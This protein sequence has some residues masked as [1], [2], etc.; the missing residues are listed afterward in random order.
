MHPVLARF[1]DRE[2]VIPTVV[3]DASSVYR[4]RSCKVKRMLL[5]AYKQTDRSTTVSRRDDEVWAQV[6]S[7][8]VDLEGI[9]PVYLQVA[10]N[11]RWHV[12]QWQLPAGTPL[13]AEN[14]LAGLYGVSRD[15]VRRAYGILRMYGMIATRR[16]AG[17]YLK[18][19]PDL[20]SVKVAPGS[21]ITAVMRAARSPEAMAALTPEGRALF[22]PVITVEEPGRLPAHYDSATTVVFVVAEKA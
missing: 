14:D 1:Q 19:R 20:Q 16:G 21:R 17:H 6:D 9:V 10:S 22:S 11:I 13:P 7:S 18:S 2:H 12:I 15:T 5:T 4:R 3:D 8:E